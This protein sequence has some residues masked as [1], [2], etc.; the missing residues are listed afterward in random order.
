MDTSHPQPEPDPKT[1]ERTQAL[2]DVLAKKITATQAAER[3]GVSRKTWHEW[4]DRGLSAMLQAMQNRPDGRPP[5]PV[6]PEKEQLKSLVRDLEAK[7]KEL[8][9]SRRVL[10]AFLPMQVANPDAAGT[11]KK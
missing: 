1:T 3:L 11:K 9:C 6:D 4:Q 10:Q 5:L 2:L 7:I 8:E